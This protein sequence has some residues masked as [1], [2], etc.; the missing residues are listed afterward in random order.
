[1]KRKQKMLSQDE[2]VEMRWSHL[3]GDDHN[4]TD[5]HTRTHTINNYLFVFILFEFQFI[6]S[7]L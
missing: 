1:M 4:S 3:C 5:A 7:I 2:N 6:L